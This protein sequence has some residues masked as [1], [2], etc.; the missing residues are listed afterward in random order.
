MALSERVMPASPHVLIRAIPS[1][2]AGLKVT[3][4]PLGAEASSL[5][6]RAD[7][8][9]VLW[10]VNGKMRSLPAV[11]LP[12]SRPSGEVSESE[13]CPGHVEKQPGVRRYLRARRPQAT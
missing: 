8:V 1:T 3:F 12:E 2:V 6:A 5:T 7:A 11:A 13:G 4:Q 9:P 10:R